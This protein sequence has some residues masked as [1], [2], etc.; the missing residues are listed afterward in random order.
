M[1]ITSTHETGTPGAVAGFEL[2]QLSGDYTIDPAHSQIGFTARH[3]MVTKVRGAFN[4]FA[5]RIHLDAARPSGSSAE[6]TI[7]VASV[8]TRNAQRDGHLLGS[9]FFA[10]DQYPEIAFRS[11]A[12]ERT[13]EDEVRVTGDL[14][15]RGVTRPV[16]VDLTFTGAAVDL[17]GTLRVGF[18]GAARISRKEWG[19]NF[20]V[21]LDAGGVLISDEVRLELEIQ[22]VKSA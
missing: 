19:M 6:I 4:E 21:A 17:Q 13:G 1:S 20:N 9:D 7:Q 14:T 11:T 8:D 22:A 2:D 12:V 18:E 16:A 3:M 10:I 5:G 15:V